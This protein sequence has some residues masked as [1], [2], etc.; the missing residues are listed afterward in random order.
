MPRQTAQTFRRQVRVEHTARYLLYRPAGYRAKGRQ[1]WPLLVFLHGMGE[2]G[3]ELRK[4]KL[5]GPPKLIDQGTQFPFLVVSPQCRLGDW[6]PVDTLEALLDD[7]LARHRVD[8][9]RV[10]LTGLSMGGF[11]AFAWALRSPQRFAAVVPICGGGN[12]LAPHAYTARRLA[13]LKSLPFRVF[14]GADDP[15]VP[16][17]ESER[18]TQALR[19]FGCP[20]DLTVYPDTG[21]DAWT[22]TYDN[23][24]LYQWLLQHRRK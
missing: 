12:P 4:V 13:A 10:Y 8:R 5:H 19:E 23:P 21:H 15:V 3:G 11:G 9:R 24:E 6:W 22:R 20:V 2:R 14:H 16:R 1:T 17:A 18:M 7:V